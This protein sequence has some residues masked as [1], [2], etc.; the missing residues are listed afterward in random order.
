MSETVQELERAPAGR[1][2]YLD[3]LKIALTILVISHH[4]SIAF[5]ASGGWYYVIPPPEGSLAPVVLTLFTAVN[6]AFFM[7]LFF[8]ISA[9][10]T[11]LSC[12]RKGVAWFLK[13]RFAR[14]GIPLVVYFF[15]LNPALVYLV[16]RFHGQTQEG[17]FEF[18][19]HHLLSATGTG[20]LWFVLAL[21]IFAS[22][23]AALRLARPRTSGQSQP[24]P[25]S[26][27]VLC[28]VLANGLAA[29]VVRLI[30][31]AGW[32]ILG[33]QLGYFPL[34][35]SMYALGALASRRGWLES[36]TH[37]QARVW[38]GA[39]ILLILL[40]PVIM[41]WGGALEGKGDEFRGG[42]NALAAIYAFWEPVLC[43]GI[44]MQLLVLFRSRFNRANALSLFAARGAYTAYIIHPFFV[45][46]GTRMLEQSALD[47]IANFLI[48][49]V[50]ASVACFAC[51][52]VICRA[53]LLRRIL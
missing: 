46:L 7:S 47:P 49:S 42:I 48:L 11:P 5:G 44:S 34:Y 9:F 41:V 26:G 18:I 35:I 29:F 27:A 21:L 8:F 52:G 45:V 19:R 6:Q 33:L 12:D 16:R 17:F 28:F 53:P 15:L 22:V 50:A 36:L 38:F 10:F 51:A 24:M 37:R 30:F 14:L 2:V 39:S 20:P 3:N 25:G 13:D 43:V 1:L 40:L 32:G 23:Y 31:P 4:S